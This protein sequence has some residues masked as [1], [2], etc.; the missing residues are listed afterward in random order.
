MHRGIGTGGKTKPRLLYV[1]REQLKT[2]QT[3]RNIDT[4]D[5]TRRDETK[6]ETDETAELM[7]LGTGMVAGG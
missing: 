3:L 5:E 2:D 4:L 6:Q 7:R 1:Q